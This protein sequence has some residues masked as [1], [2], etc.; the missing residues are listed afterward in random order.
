MAS[1]DYDNP[2]VLEARMEELT[3]NQVEGWNAI[4]KHLDL[5]GEDG[6]GRFGAVKWNLADRREEPWA[7]KT[8]R[9]VLPRLPLTRIPPAYLPNVLDRFS[10]TKLSKS[11]RKVGEVD[12]NSHYR[13]GVARDWENHFQPRHHEKF[14]ELYGN[15]LE[16]LGYE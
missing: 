11:E 1:W 7:F 3:V 5:L 14:R 6:F 9:R 16:R 12:E 2:R 10:F 13:K 4:M 8:M 15:L